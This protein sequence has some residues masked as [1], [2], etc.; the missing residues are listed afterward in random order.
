MYKSP[1]YNPPAGSS[2]RIQILDPAVARKIAAGEVIDRPFSVVRELIDNAID[3]GSSEIEVAVENG[4]MSLIRVTDNGAGMSPEDLKQCFLPHATSKIASLSDLEKIGSLGFRGE[5][6]ASIAAVSRTQII[7]AEDDSQPPYRIVVRDGKLESAAPFRGKKGTTVESAD[8]FYSYPG[9][10]RFLKSPS[11]E[12]A[13]CSSVTVEKALPFPEI[14]FR[15][16][17]GGTL[18]LFLP[19]GG[20]KDRV[21]TANKLEDQND[22]FYEI[23]GSGDGFTAVIVTGSPDI[24]RRDRRYMQVFVN[25]RRIWEFSLVQA[26]EYAYSSFLPGGLYPYCFVFLRMDPQLVDFNIHPAKKEARFRSV[27]ETRRRLISMIDSFLSASAVRSA[28]QQKQ[29]SQYELPSSMPDTSLREKVS[30]AGEGDREFN[31][32]I[33][34]KPAPDTWRGAEKDHK[35]RYLG[36]VFLTFLAVEY[37]DAFYLIDQHA[38]HERLLFDRFSRHGRQQPLLIPIDLHPDPDEQDFICRSKERF[39]EIGIVL[40][41]KENGGWRIEAVPETFKGAE[42]YLCEA[43]KGMA[44]TEKQL[45]TRLYAEMSCKAA[46][47]AGEYCDTLTA[48]DLIG[49]VFELESPRC[50]HGRPVYFSLSRDELYQFVGRT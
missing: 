45:L 33:H 2:R 31:L 7:S 20:L 26:I 6:L 38:A 46:I 21:V 40:S 49:S 41:E 29:S 48:E 17:S 11:A 28:A 3:A 44:G 15:Y 14:T 42:Q 10:K 4:G 25:G 37:D 50:P 23:E 19:A 13:L 22:F 9:R 39:A 36:Q 34:S 1:R 24:Y 30:E 5:A 43:I 16:F 47:K 18:R 35:Y 8:L 27:Q 12:A 32:D